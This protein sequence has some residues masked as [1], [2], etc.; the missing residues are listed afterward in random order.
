M[1]FWFVE[2]VVNYFIDELAY[3]SFCYIKMKNLLQFTMTARK[4]HRCPGWNLQLFCEDP[5]LF[6]WV[7]DSVYLCGRQHPKYEQ[8]IRLVHPPFFCK[9]L[10]SSN[11]TQ[12]KKSNKVRSGYSNSCISVTV[13]NWAPVCV[14]FF[15]TI[16]DNIASNILI[17]LS[18]SP[19]ITTVLLGGTWRFYRR[20][21]VNYTTF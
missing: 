8:A 15:L 18:E 9:L 20:C 12:K 6:D 17:F 5:M 7:D 4:F 14:N 10:S 21:A 13:H 1:G 19:C 3:I 16:S 11:P 2:V